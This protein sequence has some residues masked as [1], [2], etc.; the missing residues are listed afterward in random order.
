MNQIF[1]LSLVC[2]KGVNYKLEYLK[3]EV[4]HAGPRAP[5]PRRPTAGRGARPPLAL[6]ASLQGPG[7]DDPTLLFKAIQLHQCI[8]K[9][10]FDLNI[11]FYSF[12]FFLKFPF[13]EEQRREEQF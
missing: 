12:F 13:L 8:E 9:D 1:F 6:A 3:S 11:K 7:Q 10:L 5:E 4:S 2:L